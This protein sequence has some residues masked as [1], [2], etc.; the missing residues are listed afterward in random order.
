MITPASGIG[1][2][3]ILRAAEFRSYTLDVK[4]DGVRTVNQTKADFTYALVES[5]LGLSGNNFLLLIPGFRNN[6]SVIIR[7]KDLSKQN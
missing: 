4:D 2:V 6:I 1:T 7:K 3:I 5:F